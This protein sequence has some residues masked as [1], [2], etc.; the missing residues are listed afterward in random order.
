MTGHFT[1]PSSSQKSQAEF[2]P[3][4]RQEKAENATTEVTNM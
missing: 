1:I 3:T 2:Q 4:A